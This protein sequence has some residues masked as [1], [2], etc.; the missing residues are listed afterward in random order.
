MPTPL[1]KAKSVF[2]VPNVLSS[3]NYAYFVPTFGSTKVK[4]S[5]KGRH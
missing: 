3:L 1:D 5:Q 4:E 2:L